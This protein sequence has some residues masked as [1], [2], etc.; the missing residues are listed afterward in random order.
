MTAEVHLPLLF[1]R[2]CV[3]DD[4]NTVFFLLFPVAWWWGMNAE[5]GGVSL[6]DHSDF[7]FP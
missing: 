3:R 4:D 6:W 5:G 1:L 2:G 7:F